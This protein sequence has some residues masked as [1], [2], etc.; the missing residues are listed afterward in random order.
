MNKKQQQEVMRALGLPDDLIELIRS[1]R[2][3]GEIERAYARL[4]QL[5]ERLDAFEREMPEKVAR[6]P[7]YEAREKWKAEGRPRPHWTEVLQLRLPDMKNTFYNVTLPKWKLMQRRASFLKYQKSE[8]GKAT[9]AMG[10]KRRKEASQGLPE[11]R[12]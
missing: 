12:P 9:K 8:K 10:V 7:W 1:G 6:M 11:S 5:N 4:D 3:K 2:L